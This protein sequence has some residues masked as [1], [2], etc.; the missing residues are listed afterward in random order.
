MKPT[1][2]QI[3]AIAKTEFRFGLRRGAPVVMTALIGLLLAAGIL[4]NTGNNLSMADPGMGQFTPDQVVRLT[5][6][7]ITPGVYRSLA[8]DQYADHTAQDTTGAW[9]SLYLAL[10]LLPLAAAGTIPADRQFGVS[11]LLRSLPL[12]GNVYLL[13]KIFGTLSLVLFIALFP[14]LLFLSVLEGI[15]SLAYGGGIP[16]PLFLFFMELSLVDGLPVLVFASSMGVLAGIGSRSRR[17]AILPGLVT[18]ILAISFWLWAFRS[19]AL[20]PVSDLVDIFDLA[21]HSVFQGYQ[22]IWQA[23]WTRVVGM[24]NVPAFDLTLLGSDAPIVRMGQVAGMYALSLA[25]LAGVYA[26]ARRWLLWKENF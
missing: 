17:T 8:R 12:D 14:F 4:M 3:L 26:L 19:V 22:N 9:F 7:G 21:A 20:S 23:S 2:R 16:L 5:E 18:G 11:E 24:G 1:V 10:L 25:I 6:R 15:L 13:G